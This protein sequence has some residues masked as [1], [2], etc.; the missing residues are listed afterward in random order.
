M[1]KNKLGMYRTW[2]NLKLLLVLPFFLLPI[3]CFAGTV[4]DLEVRHPFYVGAFYGY[5]ATTWQGLVP[6]EE[7][8]N[9]ALAMST[10]IKVREGGQS[11]GFFVGHEFMPTFAIEANYFH[12]PNATIF[13]DKLSM[14]SFNNDDQTELVSQTESVNLMGKILLVVPATPIRFYSGAGLAAIHRKDTLTSQ[15]RYSPTFGLGINYRFANHF[16]AE[17]NG[18]YTAGYGESQLEPSA[19]FFPFLYSMTFRLA[20]IF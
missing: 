18:N 11:W 17:L 2:R 3:R 13:F 9:V 5:G 19:T 15:W 6:T 1:L 8:Q 14:F 10:P 12:Y 16:M 20:Y 7:N 4:G